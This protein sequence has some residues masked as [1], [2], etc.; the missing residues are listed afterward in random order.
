MGSIVIGGKKVKDFTIGGKKVNSITV[1]G[2]VLS[3]FTKPKYVNLGNLL[4]SKN[5]V[6]RFNFVNNGTTNADATIE[7]FEV[8]FLDDKY[9]E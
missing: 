5:I 9:E 2:K 1:G 4:T 8:L 3:F 7:N 6:I